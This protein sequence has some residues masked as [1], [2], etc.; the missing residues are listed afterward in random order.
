MISIDEAIQIQSLLIN[1]FG[2]S[3]GLRDRKL[4]ESA[5]MRPYQ[6]F[7]NKELYPT[8]P[9]KA[10][11]V[12]ESNVINHPFVDG[13]KR[14]GYVTMRLTLMAYRYDIS[15]DENDKYNFVKQIASG[16]LKY[17]E[18][19]QWIKNKIIENRLD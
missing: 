6:T 17:E 12:I 5:L 16:E 7:D 18:I 2:G 13:N 10:A 4:L 15:A 8:P 1:K 19:L 11:A 14:F 3:E 9:E